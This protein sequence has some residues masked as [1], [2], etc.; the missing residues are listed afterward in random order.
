MK[1]AD[2]LDTLEILNADEVSAE[3]RD[4]QITGV[5]CRAQ[6]VTPGS[7]FIAVKGFTADGHDFI[8][9]A[10]ACGAA[11]VVCQMISTSNEIMNATAAKELMSRVFMLSPRKRE[12]KKAL[13]EK[14]RKEMTPPGRPALSP[15]R[16]LPRL[17]GRR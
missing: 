3:A 5:F 16:S 11:A 4:A 9:Q 2:L 8:D 14:N 6:D 15:A 17:S 13:Q 7:M 10:V 12:V 1:L